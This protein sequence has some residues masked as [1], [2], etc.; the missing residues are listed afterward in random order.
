MENNNN[1]RI[2][3]ESVFVELSHGSVEHQQWLFNHI[4]EM[5]DSA[6]PGDY[7]LKTGDLVPNNKHL[8]V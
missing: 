8:K 7:Q 3:M 5:T 4:K 1:I 2:F 6:F